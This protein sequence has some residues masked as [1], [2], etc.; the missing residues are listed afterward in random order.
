MGDEVIAA[1][2]H[3][4]DRHTM[5]VR[6]VEIGE[7]LARKATVRHDHGPKVSVRSSATRPVGSSCPELPTAGSLRW[8]RTCSPRWTEAMLSCFGCPESR[9]CRRKA[10]WS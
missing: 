1:A 5:A 6:E 4:G 8:Y 7:A 3:P 2:S 9:K 10:P